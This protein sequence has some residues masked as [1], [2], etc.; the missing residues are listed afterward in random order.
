MVHHCYIL[1]N[2]ENRRTYNG[3]TNNLTRRLRQHNQELKGGAKYTK[4][5]GNKTWFIVAYV[6]GYPDRINALQCEWRIKHPDNKRKRGPKYTGA[7]GRIKGLNEVLKLDRWTGNS[8]IDNSNLELT[9]HVL[10][11]Y[12]HL[13]T[14]LPE[15]IQTILMYPKVEQID[16][17]P[18]S[19]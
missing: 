16:T 1:A 9:V 10:E 12:A 6:S 11:E 7:D 8:T 4:D 15:N 13:L 19:E 2:K 3:Y 18:P 17:E 14:N 5:F